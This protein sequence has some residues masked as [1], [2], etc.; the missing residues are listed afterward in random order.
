MTPRLTTDDDIDQS[1]P[2]RGLQENRQS[3]AHNL[4]DNGCEFTSDQAIVY[5]WLSGKAKTTQE[6]Y[7]SIL[8]TFSQFN[9]HVPIKQWTKQSINLWLNCRKK[10][11]DQVSTLNKKLCCLRSLLGH[12]VR[13]GYVAK[14]VAINIPAFKPDKE[15]KDRQTLEAIERY[16]SPTDVKKMLAAT[17]NQRDRLALK[18]AYQLALRVHEVS[19]IHWN[20]FSEQSHGYYRLKVIGKNGKID[21]LR[22]DE[23]L[24]NQMRALNSEGYVFRSRKGNK[25]SRPQLHRIVKRAVEKANLDPRIS[26]HWLRHA[27]ISHLANDSQFTL[28]Q[29]RKFARHT[30]LT[31]TST[32]VHCEDEI[33]SDSL[34]L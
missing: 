10:L 7:F 19:N 34:A 29:V 31:I 2:P 20:D 28:E 11:G 22:I 32:Y 16:I 30:N 8:Q 33:T 18:V 24:V 1:G 14:N 21:F 27:R 15:N 3:L 6:V 9:G 5:D 23:E 13:E 4:H 17:T 12:C 25:L 26:F